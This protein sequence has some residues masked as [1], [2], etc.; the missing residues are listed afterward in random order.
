MAHLRVACDRRLRESPAAHC[1][2]PSSRSSR[3]P[4]A[5]WHVGIDDFC[6]C[7]PG[8]HWT[9]VHWWCWLT[10]PAFARFEMLLSPNRFFLTAKPCNP[11]ATAHN[12]NP[13]SRHHNLTPNTNTQWHHLIGTLYKPKFPGLLHMQEVWDP[14]VDEMTKHDVGCSVDVASFDFTGHGTGLHCHPL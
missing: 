14:I 3:W 11:F 8:P 9:W 13:Q 6:R 5:G 7:G 2:P 1:R 4:P 12:N 10:L